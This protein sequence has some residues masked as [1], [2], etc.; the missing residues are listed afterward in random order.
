M[1]FSARK[2]LGT[3]SAII[4][5]KCRRLS[6]QRFWSANFDFKMTKGNKT[7]TGSRFPRILM[8]KVQ[9][10][11]RGPRFPRI[12]RFFGTL[13][14]SRPIVP[15]FLGFL[16]IL[17]LCMNPA[18]CSSGFLGILGLCRWRSYVKFCFVP[19][20]CMF[21][22]FFDGES[23]NSCRGYLFIFWWKFWKWRTGFRFCS[24]GFF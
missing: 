5:R 9:D 12:P 23:Q 17:G 7:C 21:P 3:L 20:K 10:S 8:N 19:K 4:I 15:K 1:S 11:C 6:P 13:S 14:G 16:G 2:E 22:V 24:I 18:L